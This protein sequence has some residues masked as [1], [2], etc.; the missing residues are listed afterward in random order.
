MGV[1]LIK[2]EKLERDADLQRK[3]CEKNW[4]VTRPLDGEKLERDV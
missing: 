1:A 3:W 4:N 2:R